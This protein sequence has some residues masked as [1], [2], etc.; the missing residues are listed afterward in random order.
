MMIAPARMAVRQ[1]GLALLS[2]MALM[3]FLTAMA[4]VVVRDNAV[5]R[6][7]IRARQDH[8]T[9]LALAEAG[10]Q[11]ALHALAA[12]KPAVIDGA[13]GRGRYHAEAVAEPEAAVY[14]IT[15]TGNARPDMPNALPKRLTVRA[16]ITR[17]GGRPSVRV[18]S[19]KEG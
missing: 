9:A 8:A 5:R 6:G 13:V 7:H 14:L 15:A 11:Q 2:T 16:R 12:G 17:D 3:L 18:L 1:R 19:W 4:V 10:V